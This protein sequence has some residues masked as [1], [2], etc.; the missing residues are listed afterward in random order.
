MTRI[1]KDIYTALLGDIKKR[2]H[3]AQYEALKA[4]NK[5]LIGLYWDIGKL[6]IKR[7]ETHDTKWGKATVERIAKDIQME[8][9]GIRGFSARNI[10]YMRNFYLEYQSKRKLQPLVAEISW[11]HNLIIME[12]C[13]DVLEREFYMRMSR[14]T[15]WTKN[16]LVHQIDNKSYEKTLV[17]QTNFKKNLPK[18]SQQ[19]AKLAVRDEYTFDFLELGDEH[20]ERDLERAII[21][22]IERFLMEMGGMFAFIGSQYRLEVDND[23]FYIDLLLYHRQLRSLVAIDLKIGKFLPE[24]VGKMGFYLE[25]LDK[26]VRLKD[27]NPS[28]GIILCRTKNKTVVEYAL[29]N[30]RRPI[31]VSAYESVSTLPKKYQGKLPSPRQISLLLRDV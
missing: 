20:S 16:V 18:V 13:K 10:W 8:F 19:Q 27:E 15:G 6:I 30:S 4:V 29:N 12:R 14:R 24:Y 23:E 22:K 7:Q 28:I 31:G 17:A 26:M 21:Q 11:S 2:I 25:T 9:P 1:T 3:S 5:E